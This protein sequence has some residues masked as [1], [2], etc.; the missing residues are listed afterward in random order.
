MIKI[1][2]LIYF[3]DGKIEGII[4]EIYKESLIVKIT[5]TKKNGHDQYL[6]DRR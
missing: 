6:R 2:E 5:S 3:D 1:G 4:Q